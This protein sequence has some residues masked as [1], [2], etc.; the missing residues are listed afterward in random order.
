MRSQLMDLTLVVA[1]VVLPATSLLAQQVR[2]KDPTPFERPKHITAIA[3]ASNP[4]TLAQ[5]QDVLTARGYTIVS[6]ERDSGELSAIKR[7]SPSSPKSDRVLIWLERD[8]GKP[9][10][11]AYIYLL[12]GRFEPF[13]G[14][15][16]GPVRVRMYD[17]ELARMTV[18]QDAVIAFANSR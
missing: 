3:S 15:T 5:L 17:Y 7:D 11:R 6:I 4:V 14:S 2:L 9:G 16:E 8:P 13:V 1:C 12:Y 10:E 18:L